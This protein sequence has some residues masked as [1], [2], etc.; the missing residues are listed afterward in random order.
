MELDQEMADLARMGADLEG[1]RQSLNSGDSTV[2]GLIGR[3]EYMEQSME[4]VNAH[5]L[6]I[7]ES[8]LR[9][10]EDVEALQRATGG[11]F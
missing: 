6:Q 11:S 5:R 1:I 4:S 10:R 9:I 2:L 7:N 8:L 3:I